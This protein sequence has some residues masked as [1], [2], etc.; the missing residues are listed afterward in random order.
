[1]TRQFLSL[2]WSAVVKLMF[3]VGC[4]S[5]L[6]LFFFFFPF[7]FVRRSHLH[8]Y[9]PPPPPPPPP[10]AQHLTQYW[11]LLARIVW[12]AERN[13]SFTAARTC[14]TGGSNLPCSTDPIQHFPSMTVRLPSI[15]PR[16]HRAAVGW[17][18]KCYFTSTETV[19]LLHGPTYI[20]LWVEA[21]LKCCRL[22]VHRN[23]RFIRDGSPA[24]V[25]LY[26]HRNRRFIRDG[27]PVEVLYGH[28]NRRVY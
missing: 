14:G 16:F 15:A 24:E 9:P 1:M 25:L 11:R 4:C 26:G 3:P 19:G 2:H 17:W 13:A 28:R 6:L 18:L 20:Y 23:G 21:Q 8:L 12:R 22:Y 5:F 27:S 7:Q 10:T